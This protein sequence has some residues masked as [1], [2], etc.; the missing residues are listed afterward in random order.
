MTEHVGRW[1][2]VVGAVAAVLGLCLILVGR[3]APSGRFLPGDIVVRRPG[4][5]LYLP[6]ATC[7]AASIL[8]TLAFWLAALLRR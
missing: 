2:A 8:L 7:V 1:L 4:F 5:T 6:L 3:F